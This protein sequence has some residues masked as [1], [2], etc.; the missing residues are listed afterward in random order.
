[1][2]L[3]TKLNYLRGFQ[4]IEKLQPYFQEVYKKID[5]T[6]YYVS[7]YGNVKNAFDQNV[8][9]SVDN[10]GYKRVFILDN[11]GKFITRRIHRLVAIA[12]LDNPLGKRVVDHKDCD[13]LNNHISNLR[14]ASHSENSMNS[15]QKK[16]SNTTFKGVRKT[17]YN[18]YTA[19]IYLN[20][21]RKSLGTF[22][23]LDE[24]INARKKGAQ[25]YYK[26]FCH[27]DELV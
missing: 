14:W 21:L 25:I 6:N 17:K 13:K 7:S 27:K 4:L 20:G 2:Y 18:T 10:V 1:M 24:A 19:I 11:N 16:I 8:N 26:E 9:T 23:T 5:G 3:Q 12:F 15:K 22:K